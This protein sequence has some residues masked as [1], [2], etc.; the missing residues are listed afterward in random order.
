MGAIL[1]VLATVLWIY[2]LILIGR[3]ILDWVQVFSRD[4]QPKGILLV[5]AEAI[6]T[7]TD[8]RPQFLTSIGLVPAPLVEELSQSSDNV[9]F[10]PVSFEL[11]ET[12]VADVT[13]FWF[14]NDEEYATLMETEAYKALPA[15]QNG[16]F[17]AI[18]GE[19]LVMATSAF[20]PLSIPYALEAFLPVLASAAANA[21]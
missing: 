6:Y 11:A 4:W 15:V 8:P 1:G 19:S 13:I 7:V 3:L 5:I 16:T 14:T 17:G 9:Y 10:G 12:L 18:V 21:G 20:S 2:W